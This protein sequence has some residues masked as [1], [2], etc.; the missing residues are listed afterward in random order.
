[1]LIDLY[2]LSF[3]YMIRCRRVA[4]SPG[5]CLRH[6]L[7]SVRTSFR[8]IIDARPAGAGRNYLTCLVEPTR[9]ELATS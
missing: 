9:I 1:M 2:L 6:S 3:L 7:Y 4:T 8:T 5:V